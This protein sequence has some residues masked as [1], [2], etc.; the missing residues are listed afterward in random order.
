MNIVNQKAQV[1]L[2]SV[3]RNKSAPGTELSESKE[4]YEDIK[5]HQDQCKYLADEKIDIIEQ[6]D[7]VIDGH[8]LQLDKHIARFQSELRESGSE[9]KPMHDELPA[10]IQNG[11]SK[12]RKVNKFEKEPAVLKRPK[13]IMDEPYTVKLG[14]SLRPVGLDM[15]GEEQP[16][17][18]CKCQRQLEDQMVECDNPRCK[19]KWFHFSCVGLTAAPSEDDKWYCPDCSVKLQNKHKCSH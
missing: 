6:I 12:K 11:I 2:E 5:Q 17:T 16:M 3:K 1:Y 10:E 18:Y 19:Y 8:L 15:P 7:K 4:L 9:Q 14:T 13:R